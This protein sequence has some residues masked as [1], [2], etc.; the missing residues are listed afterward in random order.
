MRSI[1][2]MKITKYIMYILL[3]LNNVLI[4]SEQ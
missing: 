4:I 1:A 2:Y 3:M